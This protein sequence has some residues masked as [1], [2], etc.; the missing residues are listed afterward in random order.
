MV[1]ASWHCTAPDHIGLHRSA[2]HP[3]GV[4]RT[5]TGGHRGHIQD[6]GLPPRTRS[7]CWSCVPPAPCSPRPWPS[8]SSPPAQASATVAADYPPRD[9]GYHSFKEMVAHIKSVAA[10]YP[11]IVRVFSI[12]K[13]HQGRKLWAAEVSDNAGPRRGRAGDPLRRPAPRPRA[14]QRGDGHRRPRPAHEPLRRSASGSRGSSTSG[15]PGSSSWSTPTASSTTSTGHPYRDWRKN[16]EPAPG[17][18]RIGTDLNRNYGYR[19]GCCGASSGNPGSQWYRGPRAWSAP[20]VRAMR[21]FVREPRRGRPT[22]HPGAHLLPHRGRAGA[23]ALRL[24]AR[25]RAAGHDGARPPGLRGP[26]PGHGGHERLHGQAVLG[27]VRRP[28]AT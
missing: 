14:P 12:G 13:S 19:F 15:A 2:R 8:P 25:R 28:T 23:L 9:A 26:G 16:R 3:D 1:R 7:I 10:A 27:H 20:E 21:D 22:A 11:H 17:S 4:P 18:G 24:H 5:A 6:A